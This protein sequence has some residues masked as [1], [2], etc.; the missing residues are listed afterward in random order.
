[1]NEYVYQLVSS[2]NEMA[3][4]FE[5]RKKVFIEEQEIPE[6][7]EYDHHDNNCLHVIAKSGEAII[8]TARVR[9]PTLHIAKIERMAVLKPFRGNHI[10][11]NLI[12]F[13]HDMLRHKKIKRSIL[14]AQYVVIPFYQSY[15]YSKTGN[16]FWEA[17]IKH[18]KMYTNL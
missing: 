11:G 6:E 13:I 9:F 10:G 15:G 16:P 7:E 18:I 17:G 2:E 14:H 1:M 8:A 5:V 12:L 4:A 3:G